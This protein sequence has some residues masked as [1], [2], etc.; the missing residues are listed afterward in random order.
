MKPKNVKLTEVTKDANSLICTRN[1]KEVILGNVLTEIQYNML[2]AEIREQGGQVFILDWDGDK[3]PDNVVILSYKIVWTQNAQVT[4]EKIV[5]S[6]TRKKPGIMI[7][8][9]MNSLIL[10]DN[11]LII[12]KYVRL[13]E[14]GGKKQ[15]HHKM[16]IYLSPNIVPSK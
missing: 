14:W 8:G 3:V 11:P 13:E 2:L 16:V 7:G 9:N 12:G 1:P 5:P 10:A 15:Q 4:A 6:K